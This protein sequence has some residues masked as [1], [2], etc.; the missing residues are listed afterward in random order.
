MIQKV[1]KVVKVIFDHV[2]KQVNMQSQVKNILSK[3][4]V[5]EI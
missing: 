1:L 3:P 4:Q 5:S 2:T